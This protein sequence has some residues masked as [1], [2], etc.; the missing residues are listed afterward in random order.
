[1]PQ[2]DAVR[3][4]RI[5]LSSPGD[6]AEER[7]QAR[8]LLL[9]LA[10]G[11]F[12]RGRIHID[13]VS[14]DDPHAP[15]TMDG[16][17]TPQQAVD[18]SLPSPDKCDLT[19]VFLWSR[20]GTPLEEEKA[21]GTPYA[22]GTEWELEKALG[23]D[24]PVLL[25]R[26]S[27]KALL[28]PDDP[29]F[30]DKLTQKRRV[31]AYF[32]RLTGADGSMTMAYATYAS[33]A[34]LMKLL[35]QNV[36]TYIATLLGASPS[37]L[38]GAGPSR[39]RAA[40][41]PEVP[42]AYR[43]WVK[44]KHGGVDLLGLQ[45]KKSR[46][47]S[48]SA[49][50]V[51]QTTIPGWRAGGGR[52]ARTRLLHER[53]EASHLVREEESTLAVERLSAE[54]L[55][56]SG[57]P[58]TGKSTLCRWVAWLVA[59]GAMP[60]PDIA[61][62]Q[63]FTETLG[64][65]LR[66][67]LP[68]LIRLREFWEYLPVRVAATLGRADLETAIGHWVEHVKPDGL[69]ARLIQLHIEA[70]TALLILDGVDEVPLSHASSSGR[71]HPRDQILSALADSC[72][73]WCHAGN[74]LL[75]T[76]RP[77]GLSDD[78]ARQTTLGAA[79]LQLLPPKL[80]RLL[81]ER[82]FTVLASESGSGGTMAADLFT[83][84]DS[85]PWLMELAANPLL[86][87]AMAIVYDEGKRLPQDK[88]ELYER[89]VSTVLFSRYSVPADIDRVKRELAVIAYGMHTNEGRTTPKAEAT[90]HEVERW[91]RAYQ[92][93][94]ATYTAPAEADAFET[95]DA[96]L[97]HSGLLL[98]TSDDRVGFAHLS[99]QEFFAGQR[100]LTVD[101]ADLPGVFHRYADIPD[102]R[103]ALSFL[104]GRL[105]MA[106]SEPTKAITLL[107]AQLAVA[108]PHRPRALL[109]LADAA[110]VLEGKGTPLRETSRR[111]L[112]DVLLRGMTSEAPVVVRAELGSTLGRVGDHRFRADRWCLPDEDL[113]GFIKIEAGS[114]LMGSDPGRDNYAAV[115]E[116]PQ[117]P[118]DLPEFYVARYPVTTA[119][120]R[121]FVEEAQFK[122][123]NRDCL[124]GL[125]N[126][127]VTAVSWH[128]ALAYCRWLMEALRVSAQ[129]PAELRQRLLDG[130]EVALPSEAEWEKTARGT[131]G[132]IYPWGDTYDG[133]E[134]YGARN[135]V[136]TVGS[137]P[138]LASPFGALDMNINV[139][140]WTRSLWGKD[141]KPSYGYPYFGGSSG[142][143]RLN[144]SDRIRR[145]VRGLRR[146]AFVGQ[147]RA[148]AREGQLSREW[149]SN[150][151]FRVVISSLRTDC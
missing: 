69:D 60:V 86:L 112:Q 12:V 4:F 64:E 82:W 103:N 49:I 6:V 25:Y 65:G 105:S 101:E 144:A 109:V 2:G 70:G 113:L 110:L 78:Q 5:F 17:Y 129:I 46:P 100:S 137:F 55:Y 94:R 3:S 104:F 133:S 121:L 18:R 67:R 125:S 139:W 74:R 128:E 42:V 37:V 122:L 15:A 63:A 79:P 32:A 52:V 76:S 43:E 66:A 102:W 44:K 54:S 111:R 142:R 29:E 98:S 73:V 16:R 56:V 10:R 147:P 48:L 106:F 151:G 8:E 149:Y 26:R 148:A 40:G 91:L 117:H 30:D 131:D 130:W 77:Y 20:M 124:R 90:F 80:Q 1:M 120:F 146:G 107:E 75:L 47:P 27:S 72:P 92:H 19:V 132:R 50:Y 23:A 81:A 62:P 38:A 138:N 14:W 118:L 57:A 41:P 89:V 21:D 95:R 84:I 141:P 83:D 140:E 7:A 39:G 145:V 34:E 58:G 119:Q 45:L 71:W 24:K 9:G 93:D 36:E 114:F 96:L 87:T 143:E 59:E 28:D 61:P 11:P 115:E 136:M 68:V 31:D 85:Q 13:V 108:S 127:P 22:S 53:V 134:A 150:L 51:P 116:Q 97:S 35:A 33:A 88:H 126:H 123:G 99:F 135:G